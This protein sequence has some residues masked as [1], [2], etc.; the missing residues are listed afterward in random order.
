M[1]SD[2]GINCHQTATINHQSF[3]FL[4]VLKLI[5]FILIIDLQFA[6]C[7]T[8]GAHMTANKRLVCHEVNLF[9]KRS[10]KRISALRIWTNLNYNLSMLRG[11]EVFRGFN[12]YERAASNIF[13]AVLTTAM[14]IS[15][16][17]QQ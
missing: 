5:S 12:L 14:R 7:E 4:M 11:I 1:Y 16:S 15:R 17:R 3:T 2:I 13:L 9:F 6:I 8:G 10:K